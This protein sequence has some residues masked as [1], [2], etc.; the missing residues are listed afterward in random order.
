MSKS[1]VQFISGLGFV[2]AVAFTPAFAATTVPGGVIHFRGAIVSDPC[3]ISSGANHLVMACPENNRMQARTVSYNDALN[4]RSA[5]PNLA[6]VS[7]KYMNP[8]K[9]LAVVQVDYR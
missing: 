1:T 3:E 5:Y 8:E 2:F 9:S 7:M 6:S 4:G